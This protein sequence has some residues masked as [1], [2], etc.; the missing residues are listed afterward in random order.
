MSES[1][2]AIFLRAC[3]VAQFPV[4]IDFT[5]AAILPPPRF[6]YPE[7]NQTFCVPKGPN[8]QTPICICWESLGLGTVY[9]LQISNNP[10]FQGPSTRERLL[11]D[12]QTEYCLSC[13]QDIRYGDT[14]YVRLIAGSFVFGT[15]AI[16]SKSETLQIAWNCNS[17]TNDG[18]NDLCAF[19]EIDGQITGSDRLVGCEYGSYGVEISYNCKNPDNSDLIT[20]E[21]VE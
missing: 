6:K 11:S 8:G 13:P 10:Q 12:P 21:S 15:P 17:E 1:S 5:N 7:N 20:L 4:D 18:Q 14:V 3:S 9:L 2:C 19:Y 16:S